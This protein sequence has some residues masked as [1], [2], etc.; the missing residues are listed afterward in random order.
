MD[1]KTW[2]RLIWLIGGLALALTLLRTPALN[3]PR[4]VPLVKLSGPWNTGGFI[5]GGV[6][7]TTHPESLPAGI[8]TLGSWQDGDQWRGRVETAW[9]PVSG[10]SLRIYVAGYPQH[11]GCILDV[12]LRRGDGSVVKITC[13]IADPHETWSPW[14]LR[15]PAGA[16]S[17]R[18]VA[19]DN[20]S[21]AGGW[22]AF[23]E[24]TTMPTEIFVASYM[25]VQVFATLSL[26]LTLMWGPG[27][28][29]A[30]RHATDTGRVMWL[31][32][33]GPLTL[34]ALG[35]MIWL[36]GGLIAPNAL[37]FT[38]VGSIWLALGLRLWRRNFTP[39][40]S[41][42]S[43]QALAVS[44]LCALAA[45]ARAADSDGP[46]G[47][48]Y[49][50]LI[51]RSLAVGDRSDS[52]IS[53]YIPQI[54]HRHLS[55]ASAERPSDISRHGLFSAEGRWRASPPRRFCLRPVESPSRPDPFRQK[56]LG[57]TAGNGLIREDLPPIASF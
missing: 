29:W 53:Y 8:S 47:E 45:V 44:A 2:S 48:L 23:S 36:L 5:S 31:L 7:P 18:I 12:E 22:L 57:S 14:D 49:G 3:S 20:A 51:A 33:A 55:P 28:L 38:F 32:G 13:P 43:V 50:G 17:M 46:E 16:V 9:L 41:R 39:D 10:Q 54:I 27:L 56:R 15:V 24:P 42:T 21:D 11:L 35:V 25:A 6:Y 1:S 19:E 34:A 26:T 4:A 37:G 40:L 52:R 30:P